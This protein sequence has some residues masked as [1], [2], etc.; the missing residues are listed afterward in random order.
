MEIGY[1]FTKKENLS[2]IIEKCLLPLYGKNC[3]L[4]AN[5]K[6]SKVS[7]SYGEEN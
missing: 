4:L 2:S 3:S 7:F 5:Q 6:G 1:H